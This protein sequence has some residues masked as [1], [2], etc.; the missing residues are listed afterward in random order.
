MEL[1]EGML[2]RTFEDAARD[3]P[4]IAAEHLIVDNCAHQLVKGP[5][6]STSS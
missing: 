1:T 3:Y 6:S 5:S 4:D 2:K